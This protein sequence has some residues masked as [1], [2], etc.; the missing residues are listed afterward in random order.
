MVTTEKEFPILESF[1]NITLYTLGKLCKTKDTTLS[2]RD[3]LEYINKHM[4][5]YIES[6]NIYNVLTGL[7]NQGKLEVVSRNRSIPNIY[8]LTKDGYKLAKSKI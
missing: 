4:P 7:I 5:I 8:K 3:I 6:R 1:P 2:S